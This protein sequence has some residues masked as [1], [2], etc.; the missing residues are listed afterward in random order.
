MVVG[1]QNP[2]AAQ[3]SIGETSMPLA[4]NWAIEIEAVPHFVCHFFHR[5][6]LRKQL[7]DLGLPLRDTFL[8]AE[9]L[10]L[11]LKVHHRFFGDQG[12]EVGEPVLNLPN[13]KQEFVGSRLF[14]HVGRSLPLHWLIRSI[15]STMPKR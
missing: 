7:K 5:H 11:A 1:E 10:L 2:D 4:L 6:P 14:K 8:F 3:L 9:M 15:T 13:S 12:R